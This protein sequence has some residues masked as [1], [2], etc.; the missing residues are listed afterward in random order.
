MPGQ[1]ACDVILLVESLAKDINSYIA[2][3]EEAE[4]K[5]EVETKAKRKIGF[6]TLYTQIQS[7]I[8]NMGYKSVSVDEFSRALQGIVDRVKK[9]YDEI[10]I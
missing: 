1:A 6:R 8:A 9:E 5:Q 2:K 3:S 10:D 4:K 7:E